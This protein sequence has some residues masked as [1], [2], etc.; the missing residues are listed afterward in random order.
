MALSYASSSHDD[1]MYMNNPFSHISSVEPTFVAGLTAPRRARFRRNAAI[2]TLF[3]LL[4]TIAALVAFIFSG[5][6]EIVPSVNVEFAPIITNLTVLGSMQNH[7]T[8]RYAVDVMRR[9]FG[10]HI[11]GAQALDAAHDIALQGTAYNGVDSFSR[12]IDLNE[13]SLRTICQEG[14]LCGTIQPLSGCSNNR[15]G[16]QCSDCLR[17]HYGNKCELCDIDCNGNGVCNEGIS[18]DNTCICES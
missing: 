6:E 2:A 16:L 13:K 11:E 7:A 15:T 1:L 17:G 14:L 12:I 4:V 5:K 3:I 8:S 18:G 9:T 10:F